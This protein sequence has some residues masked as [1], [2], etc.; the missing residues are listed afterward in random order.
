MKK[1]FWILLVVAILIVGFVFI[2]KTSSDSL[3]TTKA[4]TF[5]NEEILTIDYPKLKYIA[6]ESSWGK[7]NSGRIERTIS[8][9]WDSP[10]VLT[11]SVNDETNT[12]NYY[13]DSID[14]YIRRRNGLYKNDPT[15]VQVGNSDYYKFDHE[16]NF[17]REN[18]VR[19]AGGKM[20]E[21]EMGTCGYRASSQDEVNKIINSIM[22]SSK[23]AGQGD[24]RPYPSLP[25]QE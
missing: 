7:S 17:A 4:F 2:I 14:K 23:Y 10:T 15:I 19:F 13:V 20:I 12:D 3:L 11:V 21:I 8:F 24:L 5:N 22:L 1:L 6:D 25:D 9:C 16:S 18:Y